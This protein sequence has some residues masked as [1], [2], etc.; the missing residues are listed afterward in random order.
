MLVSLVKLGCTL[1]VNA[2]GAAVEGVMDEEITFQAELT[3][4]RWTGEYLETQRGRKRPITQRN[5]NKY[6]PHDSV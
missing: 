5:W 3:V 2:A 4:A 1:T 6:K